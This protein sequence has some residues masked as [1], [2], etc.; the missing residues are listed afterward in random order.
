MP[1]RRGPTGTFQSSSSSTDY[2]AS[3]K[4]VSKRRKTSINHESSIS[5]TPLPAVAPPAEAPTMFVY[6]E[7]EIS[8]SKKLSLIRMIR[9]LGMN[10]SIPAIY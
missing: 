4:P 10:G 9:R 5:E 3:S 7:S 6:K 1:K 8:A 2:A